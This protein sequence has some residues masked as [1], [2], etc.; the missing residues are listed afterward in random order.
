MEGPRPVNRTC[1]P[2]PKPHPCEPSGN[3]PGAPLATS[4]WSVVIASIE[5]L[6][7]RLEPSGSRP[8]DRS[9]RANACDEHAEHISPGVVEPRRREVHAH[10][11]PERQHVVKRDLPLGGHRFPVDRSMSVDEHTPVRQFG[12]QLVDGI[13]EAQL[14]LLHEDE[15]GHRHDRL[16]HR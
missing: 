14:V 13:V 6:D 15:R 9:I 11:Q 2:T 4:I 10:A 12:K 16:G 3:G 8:P 5:A 7:N 1:T